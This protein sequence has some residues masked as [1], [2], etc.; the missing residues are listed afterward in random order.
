MSS[1]RARISN[2]PAPSPP[3]SP[4]P[5]PTPA[6]AP[7]A[8]APARPAG[9]RCAQHQAHGGVATAHLAEPCAAPRSLDRGSGGRR[10]CPQCSGHRSGPARRWAGASTTNSA[11][12]RTGRTMGRFRRQ[13]LGA[14]LER[15]AVTIGA[16]GIR[17][18]TAQL[19]PRSHQVKRQPPGERAIAGQAASPIGRTRQEPRRAPTHPLGALQG[20]PAQQTGIALSTKRF[21]CPRAAGATPRWRRLVGAGSGGAPR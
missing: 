8:G 3:P 19:G 18:D 2:I 1:P 9:D 11:G 4:E 7:P 10:R 6:A 12:A 21:R 20:D 15:G 5:D 14:G 17:P 16:P 13:H